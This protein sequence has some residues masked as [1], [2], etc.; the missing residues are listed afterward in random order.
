MGASWAPLDTHYAFQL[1]TVSTGDLLKNDTMGWPQPHLAV[2]QMANRMRSHEPVAELGG[3]SRIIRHASGI[4]ERRGS[5][6]GVF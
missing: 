6:A 3:A 1:K 2:K 5:P 4:G